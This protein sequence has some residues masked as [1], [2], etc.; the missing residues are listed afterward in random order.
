MFFLSLIKKLKEKPGDRTRFKNQESNEQGK[1]RH[2]RQQELA[3][4]LGRAAA[5]SSPSV[6]VAQHLPNAWSSSTVPHVVVTPSIK[7]FLLLLHNC[8][9]ATVMNC[10]V[11]ICFPVVLDSPLKMM[12]DPQRV[13]NTIY[14]QS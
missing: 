9:F 5:Q 1:Q 2:K 8:N 6:P 3:E 14:K 4:H 12:F 11:N 13:K 7:L 10:N